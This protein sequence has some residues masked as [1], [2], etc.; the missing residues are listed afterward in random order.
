[1]SRYP[2]AKEPLMDKAVAGAV[3]VLGAPL[4][5]ARALVAYRQTG[6]VLH[7]RTVVGHDGRTFTLCSFAGEAIGARLPQ[8]VHV[9]RGQL[10]FVGPAPRQRPRY[11]ARTWRRP[12]GA[13]APA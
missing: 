12:R 6:R 3:L 11:I 7:T 4:L 10:R 1:M 2:L 9:V 13:R 5:G 8:L